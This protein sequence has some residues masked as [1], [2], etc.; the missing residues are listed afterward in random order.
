MGEISFAMAFFKRWGMV[1]SCEQSD[2][3]VS[4]DASVLLIE[5]KTK[6]DNPE[7]LAKRGVILVRRT[8]SRDQ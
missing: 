2:F 4:I 7:R 5:E 8:A 3:L 6:I 1:D